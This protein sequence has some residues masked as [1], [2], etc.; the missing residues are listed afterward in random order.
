MGTVVGSWRLRLLIVLIVFIIC[1]YFTNAMFYTLD[2]TI[3]EEGFVSYGEENITIDGE[4]GYNET[5]LGTEEG[6]DFLGILFSVGSF[7]TFGIIDNTFI[8]LFFN[9]VVMFTFISIGYVVYT[10]IKEW[11]PFV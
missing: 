11:I 2:G 5:D 7:L 10:F 8:R 1:I 6:G 4:L 3:N 9:F